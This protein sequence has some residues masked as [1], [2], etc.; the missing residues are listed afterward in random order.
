[1]SIEI[2]KRIKSVFI[3][4]AF[5]LILLILIS[6]LFTSSTLAQQSGIQIS[7]VTYNFEL[8]PTETQKAKITISNL[9][10]EELDYVLE[11]EN[12]TYVSEEGAPSFAAV[13]LK[14]GVTSLADWIIFTDPIE[15]KLAPKKEQVINFTI[16]VPAGAEPGGHY[17]AVFVKQIKKNAEGKTELGVSSRVGT[18]ILV[19]IPGATEKSAEIVEFNSP[20]IVWHGPV[21]FKLRVKNTGTVH[22]DSQAKVTLDP[23]LGKNTDIDLGKHTILP[24]NVRSFK[25]VWQSKYPFGYYKVSVSATDGNGQ[26]VT[27]YATLWAIP[28]VIII[29]IILAILL[30]VILISYIRKHYR[31]VKN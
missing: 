3:K 11:K 8:K 23:L 13:N 16:S 30:I 4:T 24:L 18:L 25:G 29:P 27:Q 9:N 31:V 12:F 26:P 10:T 20:K 15:G 2:F 19:S 22:Y 7:P 14:E 1:M 17:A 6:L 21:D 28:L 5:S